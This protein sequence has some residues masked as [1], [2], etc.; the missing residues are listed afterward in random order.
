MSYDSENLT[1]PD[2]KL[3]GIRYKDN[4]KYKILEKS[5]EKLT[6]DDKMTVSDLLDLHFMKEYY[7][8]M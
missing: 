8:D 3:L 5:K 1:T 2:I 7:D 6:N 4:D